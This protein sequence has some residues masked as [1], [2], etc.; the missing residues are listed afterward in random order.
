MKI[1]Q[2]S[3]KISNFIWLYFVSNSFIELFNNLE[4][5]K[6][7]NNKILQK[8]YKLIEIE[9]S[10][11]KENYVEYEPNFIVENIISKSIESLKTISFKER[12]NKI[13]G[14]QIYY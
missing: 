10:N 9:I 5:N 1:Y 8:D 6:I 4:I 13:K 7:Y 3:K 14:N 12:G 11:I 2:N